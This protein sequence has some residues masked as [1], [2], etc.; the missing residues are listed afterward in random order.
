MSNVKEISKVYLLS[1]PLEKDYK[2]TLFFENEEDQQEYFKSRIV[3]QYTDFTYIRKDNKILIPD[4]DSNHLYTTLDRLLNLGV[5]YVMYQNSDYSNRW[6]YCFLNNL[7]YIDDETTELEIQTDVI[8]TWLFDYHVRPS[9]IEREH[10]DSDKLGEHT[11]PENLETGE[12]ICNGVENVDMG[13]M[14]IIVGTTKTLSENVQGGIYAGIY[15]GVRYFA[16]KVTNYQSVNKFIAD[17]T[18]G[19]E[20]TDGGIAEAIQCIFIAPSFVVGLTE[21]GSDNHLAYSSSVLQK[22]NIQI[23]K[24]LILEDY[25]PKNKKLL[26]F[27]YNYLLASNN[28][29]GSAVYKY[30]H[31]S[32]NEQASCDF[33]MYGTICPG[34]SIRL[35]PKYYKG[36]DEHQEEG[37]NAGKFPICNWNTDVYTNWLTQNSVN[38]AVSVGMSAL[39]IAAGVGMAVGTGGAGA[40]AGG[41]MVASGIAGIAGTMGQV[42][43]QSFTPPQAEGNLNCGDIIHSMGKNT[44]SFYQM[45]IKGEFARMLDKFFDM[46]GYKVNMVKEP[47]KNHRSSWW[48]TKTIDVEIAGAIPQNDMQKIKDCYNNGITFWKEPDKLGLY[49]GDNEIV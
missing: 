1:V 4:H 23:D 28:S 10:V 21:G 45:S 48:Y 26:S 18:A 9:F 5:N 6:F 31:F 29:G 37:I 17:M 30:E 3:A 32:G 34:C 25:S 14:Y 13:E 22:D 41:G 24:N 49:W 44:F 43:Q 19:T 20:D 46:F 16:W 11:V 36:V 42:R 47:N 40:L 35:N 15:S 2:H 12:F 8:Q 38:I 39:Q 33:K 27:P 7:K